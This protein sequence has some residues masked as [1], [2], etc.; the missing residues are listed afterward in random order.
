M[1]FITDFT[2][3]TELPLYFKFKLMQISKIFQSLRSRNLA[4]FFSG[5]LIARIG[6]WMQRTAVLW[7]VYSLTHSVFMI[8]VTTFAEQF[9]SFL[10][11]IRGGIIADKYNRY[12]VLVITQILSALQAVLLTA[13]TFSGYYNITLILIL[14]V[15][16]GIVNAYDVPVRQAMINEI[17]KHKEDLHNAVALNSSLNTLGRLIGPALSGF[18]LVKYGAANCFLAN[19]ISFIAAIGAIAAM[20][21]PKNTFSACKEKSKGKFKEALDYLNKNKHLV[22]TIWIAALSSLLVSPYVTLLPVY[23]KNIFKGDAATYG[24][25]NA[26]IGI[27]AFAGA[28]YLATLSASVNF[29]K[30]LLFNTFILG[31]SLILFSYSY[32]IY[33]AIFFSVIG[34]FSSL[35][36]TSVITTIIQS[37]TAAEFRGRIVSLIAMAIFGMLPLGSLLVGYLAPI[38][39]T[40]FTVFVEGL[41]GITIGVLFY[42]RLINSSIPLN[43]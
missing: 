23:A 27:G 9:P 1:I 13:F 10:L 40:Q 37:E 36:Q 26:A 39:G 30:I 21:F 34:G 14:S 7:V 32:N 42:K 35:L 16:L 4:L 28:F 5:Q 25:L 2:L 12:K 17:I 33:L 8:G 3:G 31:I 6:M 41:L 19:A 43:K 29:R 24:W 15:F 18:V 22:T 20:K 38:V 11:S